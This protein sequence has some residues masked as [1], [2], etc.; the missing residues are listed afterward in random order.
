[1]NTSNDASKKAFLSPSEMWA[2]I[3]ETWKKQ[4]ILF[5]TIAGVLIGGIVGYYMGGHHLEGEAAAS[6]AAS[7][8]NKIISRLISFPGEVFINVL[9]MLIIPLVVA[10]MIVGVTSLGDLRETGKMG[11]RTILYYLVTTAIAATIGLLLVNIIQP[12]VGSP[13]TWEGAGTIGDTTVLERVTAAQAEGT[14]G[15]DRTLDAVM[16]LFPDNIFGAA[17]EL[18]VL[19]LIVF[20]LAFGIALI[21]IGEKGRPVTAFFEGVNEAIMKLVDWFMWVVPIGVGS[22]IASKLIG[23]A[24]FFSD[25]QAMG[26]Y[27]ATVVAGLSLHI[28]FVLPAIYF[29]VTKKNPFAYLIGILQALLTAFG[30]AS[31]TA[32]LPVTLECV[33]KNNGVGK[34][35]SGFV[36][37][38]GATANM[39]GTALYEAVSV[40]WI[41]QILG[42]ELGVSGMIIVA[43]TSTLAAIGAA[44]IPS[45]GMVMMVIVLSAADMPTEAYAFLGYIYA[46]DW[47]LDRFRTAVNV[48]G[49]AIG[50]AVIDH[51]EQRDLAKAYE[52]AAG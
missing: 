41:A 6:W 22:L 16:K 24:N 44:A 43:L 19:G 1:M 29:L 35:A 39:D 40:I 7:D 27:A 10:S 28:F 30:T 3:Q 48:G 20:S 36:L 11:W 37:P 18:N 50:A 45:A 5:L 33:Q 13:L 38:L 26:V 46:I 25:L 21:T 12:G 17:V 8:S 31:S 51:L 15:L 34:R 9:K 2:V 14:N 49:D 23:S 32:T 52:K 47:L 4:P 42:I